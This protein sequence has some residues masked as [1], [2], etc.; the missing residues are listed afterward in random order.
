MCLVISKSHNPS[1]DQL[2]DH[3]A[4]AFVIAAHNDV[5]CQF[6]YIRNAMSTQTERNDT[7]YQLGRCFRRLMLLEPLILKPFKL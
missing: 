1:E 5:N 2:L 7:N 4:A 3:G 6:S